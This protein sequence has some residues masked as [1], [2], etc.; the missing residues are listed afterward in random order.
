MAPEVR[1]SGGFNPEYHVPSAALENPAH[2]PIDERGFHLQLRELC[3]AHGLSVATMEVPEGDTRRNANTETILP[4]KKLGGFVIL[5]TEFLLYTPEKI[6][7]ERLRVWR[8]IGATHYGFGN[9]TYPGFGIYAG[10]ETIR[11]AKIPAPGAPATRLLKTTA[12]LQTAPGDKLAT[13]DVQLLVGSHTPVDQLVRK[14]PNG[15]PSSPEMW[16]LLGQLARD[17]QTFLAA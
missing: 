12:K 15:Y 1:N 3:V 16:E 13:G 2:A 11:L 10:T 4:A 5:Q 7:Q 9:P 17:S 8:R 14:D 6:R